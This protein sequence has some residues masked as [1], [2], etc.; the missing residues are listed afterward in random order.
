MRMR[1][2]P[3]YTIAA[4]L[5]IITL[6]M[7]STPVLVLAAPP[8][9]SGNLLANPSFEGGFHYQDGE[10]ELKVA[11]GWVGWYVDEGD[12]PPLWKNRRPEFGLTS[13]AIRVHHGAKAQ[14]YGIIYSTHLAG[15]KAYALGSP[16]VEPE[17]VLLPQPAQVL[18]AQPV[19]LAWGSGR[20]FTMEVYGE[21]EEGTGQAPVESVET[22][23][24]VVMEQEGTRWAIDVYASAPSAGQLA[25]MEDVLQ[26][27]LASVA[28][29]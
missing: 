7:L 1:K 5:L 28:L 27:A 17:A 21:A 13:E 12:K 14:Q 19:E 9:Q 11:D 26:R 10:G 8:L 22:H 29:Q 15:L 16:E 23:V 2:K 25:E 3:S 20:R 24:L 4:F 6:L 18:D